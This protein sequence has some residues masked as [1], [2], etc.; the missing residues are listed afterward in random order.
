LVDF[1][2]LEDLAIQIKENRKKLS[3]IEKSLSDVNLRLHEIPLKRSTESTFAKMI[4]S[5]YDDQYSSLETAK[6][7]L[8]KEQEKMEGAIRE[9]LDKFISEISSTEI[10][11]PLDPKPSIVEGKTVYK[12]KDGARYQN[13]FDILSEL[14]GLSA[15]LVVKDVMLSS[16][17]ITIAEKDEYESKQKFI[18][19]FS[20]IQNT[21]MIKK[22]P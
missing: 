16:S 15:P 4:G 19:S 7:E 17:E 9:Q 1:N 21:L 18:N 2:F 13:L 22:R 5:E 6:K 11:I 14:L 3:G 20:E 12:Y 10:I 8:E